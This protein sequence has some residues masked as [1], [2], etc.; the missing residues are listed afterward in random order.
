[1]GSH[2]MPGQRSQLTPDFVVGSWVQTRLAATCH[3]RFGQNDRGLLR[4]TAVT[5]GWNRYRNK[6]QH[7]LTLR[8]AAA[9]KLCHTA[10]CTSAA[11]NTE[12][13]PQLHT[14]QRQLYF[15]AGKQKIVGRFAVTTRNSAAFYSDNFTL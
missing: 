4:A 15:A 9:E 10:K 11:E 2:T 13:L 14:L 6:S 7:N 1:M 3:L 8:T 12:L 5:W